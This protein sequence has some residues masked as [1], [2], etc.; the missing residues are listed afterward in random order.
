MHNLANKIRSKA[1]DAFKLQREKETVA[2]ERIGESPSQIDN[3]E[4]FFSN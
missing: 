3:L 4:E 2:N 1:G